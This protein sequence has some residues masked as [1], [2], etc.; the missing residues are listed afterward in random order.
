[1]AFGGTR[2]STPTRSAAEGNET[3]DMY[4]NWNKQ[5]QKKL[6]SGTAMWPLFDSAVA[7]GDV[8]EWSGAGWQRVGHADGGTTGRKPDNTEGDV[9]SITTSSSTSV[10]VEG[11]AEDVPTEVGALSANLDFSF[12]SANSFAF[13][14]ASPT[15]EE[16]S[17]LLELAKAAHKSLK[18]SGNLKIDLRVVTKVF[19][20]PYGGVFIGSQS[21]ESSTTVGGSIKPVEGAPSGG[22]DF[23][24]GT[25]SGQ[26]YE[27][28]HKPGASADDAAYAFGSFR[29]KAIA[30]SKAPGNITL[31]DINLD[32]HLS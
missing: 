15:Y 31:R 7:V 9:L 16:T 26:I 25:S 10:K 1:M 21:S 8:L 29:F 18:E 19:Q 14:A 4:S 17:D 27:R 6:D 5:V 23:G 12:A 30:L 24:V 13:V 32:P 11:K 22:V 2:T 28:V 3:M 20:C